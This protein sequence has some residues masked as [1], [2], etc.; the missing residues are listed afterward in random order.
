[1]KLESYKLGSGLQTPGGGRRRLCYWV[2]KHLLTIYG[3]VVVMGVRG[4][5]VDGEVF[6]I[7]VGGI[8]IRVLFAVCAGDFWNTKHAIPK[9]RICHWNAL[10]SYF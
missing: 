10:I 1:L 3:V 7:S 2:V 5:G 4:Y 8:P 9:K 6:C